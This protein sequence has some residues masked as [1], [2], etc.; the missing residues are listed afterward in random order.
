MLHKAIERRKSRGPQVARDVDY[1]LFQSAPEHDRGRVAR[2]VDYD[3]FN[4]TDF[5]E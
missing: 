4:A 1:P 5:K 3:V 2:D